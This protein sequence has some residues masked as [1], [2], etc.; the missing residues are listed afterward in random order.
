MG[1]NAKEIL[2]RAATWPKE[3]IEELAEVARDI[4]ARRTG[5]YDVTP[6][7]NRLFVGDSLNLSAASGRATQQ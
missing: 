4:E 7:E 1:H 5:T 3:D 6:E 2:E